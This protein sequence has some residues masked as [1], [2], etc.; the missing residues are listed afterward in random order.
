GYRLEYSELREYTHGF[1]SNVAEILED[2]MVQQ[3]WDWL[4]HIVYVAA[5]LFGLPK[6]GGVVMS[7]SYGLLV[8][9]KPWSLRLVRVLILERPNIG[10]DI[11]LIAEY[12]GL[13]LLVIKPCVLDWYNRFRDSVL[14][15]LH[16]G[17]C[18]FQW[19][20]TCNGEVTSLRMSQLQK[21]SYP[22]VLSLYQ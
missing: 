17:T 12:W 8:R 4:M 16:C 18:Q 2:G 11:G 5:D 7:T 9:E 19:W 13:V 22:N 6:N 14:A 20:F 21:T 3:P 15:E 1:F 10:G